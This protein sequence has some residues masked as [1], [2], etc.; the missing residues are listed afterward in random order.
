MFYGLTARS[1]E[2]FKLPIRSIIA[3]LY[4]HQRICIIFSYDLPALVK[5]SQCIAAKILAGDGRKNKL[6]C[7]FIGSFFPVIPEGTIL[8]IYFYRRSAAKEATAIYGSLA[9]CKLTGI[10]TI[11]AVTEFGAV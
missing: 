4:H 7:R 8:A 10:S 3:K 2:L 1:H 9:F 6:A 11:K 5:R